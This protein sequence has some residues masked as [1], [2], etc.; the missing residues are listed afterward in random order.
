MQAYTSRHESTQAAHN[1]TCE[2]IVIQCVCHELHKYCIHVYIYIYRERER[3]IDVCIYIYIYTYIGDAREA[4]VLGGREDEAAGRDEAAP[5]R[6]QGAAESRR[7][8][9]PG[10]IM[11]NTIAYTI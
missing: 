2:W 5:R 8:L 9:L 11:I 1:N 7:G 3:E 10:A 6:H 4:E